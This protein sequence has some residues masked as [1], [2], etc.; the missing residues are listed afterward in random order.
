MHFTR[1][2]APAAGIAQFGIFWA[3]TAWNG[4]GTSAAI[5]GV[6]TWLDQLVFYQSRLRSFDFLRRVTN[7]YPTGIGA[8]FFFTRCVSTTS[9]GVLLTTDLP[10]MFLRHVERAGVSRLGRKRAKKLLGKTVPNCG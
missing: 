4:F 10:K 1:M 5:R 2:F 9:T 3:W 6:C 8:L 7:L